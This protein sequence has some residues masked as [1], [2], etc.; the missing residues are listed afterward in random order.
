MD[1]TTRAA[2]SLMKE[3]IIFE[4][5]DSAAKIKKT[6]II[7]SLLL[8]VLVMGEVEAKN[9]AFFGVSFS[10]F[11]SGKLIGFIF[12]LQF[13][14]FFHY[15]WYCYDTWMQ[16]LIR[17]TG[18]NVAFHPAISHRRS[19]D[20]EFANP[21]QL[22]L[23]SWWVSQARSL[24]SYRQLAEML[25]TQHSELA[26]LIQQAHDEF[27]ARLES[28]QEVTSGLGDFTSR[29]REYGHSVESVITEIRLAK[30]IPMDSVLLE[31]IASFDSKYRLFN[32]SQNLRVLISDILF[33]ILLSVYAVFL[34]L[35]YLGYL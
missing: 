9:L 11:S 24:Q 34:S 15:L 32:R 31:S 6:L 4:L 20:G 1:Y 13:L 33:P 2:Q 23:Y 22:S 30:V 19:S 27:C 7:L 29:F 18:V 17:V 21:S 25:E 3:C 26:E 10:G 14:S 5:P 16:F 35:K 12:F 28:G 8:V